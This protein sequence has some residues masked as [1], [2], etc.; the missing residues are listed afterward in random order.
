MRSKGASYWSSV[1][2]TS[3]QV[4][5]AIA[6]AAAFT[7]GVDFNNVLLVIFNLVLTIMCWYI[8]WRFTK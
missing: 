1:C 2:V 8:G 3:S 5:L 7:G 6:A 4:F